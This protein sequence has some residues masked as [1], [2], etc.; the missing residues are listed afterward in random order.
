MSFALEACTISPLREEQFVKVVFLSIFNELP[1]VTVKTALTDPLQFLRRDELIFIVDLYIILKNP[2][3]T[4][5]GVELR[6]S[7][8][9]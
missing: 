7:L 6:K 5:E 2:V 4:L 3:L 8:F 1:P 9:W